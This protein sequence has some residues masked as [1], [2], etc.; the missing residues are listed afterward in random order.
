[1]LHWSWH[2]VGS[3]VARIEL[4]R[5]ISQ[6]LEAFLRNDVNLERSGKNAALQTGIPTLDS[7]AQVGAAARA[8][9]G[10]IDSNAAVWCPHDAHKLSLGVGLTTRDAGALGDVP[11]PAPPW[12]GRHA[13][14]SLWAPTGSVCS[15]AA[16]AAA[17]TSLLM[18]I[19]Q[20]VSFAAR[21]A[22]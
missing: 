21:R 16:A 20:P 10:G 13:G 9:A 15:D 19:R 7:G 14:Y 5:V 4:P 8:F 3:L 17:A 11:W 18:S 2:R 12:W 6:T 22:F 1:S